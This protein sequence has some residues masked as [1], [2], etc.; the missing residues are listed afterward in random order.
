MTLPAHLL[1]SIQ[2]SSCAE[3]S[4]FHS[5]T[6]FTQLFQAL[7]QL[8][9]SRRAG[10]LQAVQ[11]APEARASLHYVRVTSETPRAAPVQEQLAAWY[12]QRWQLPVSTTQAVL[13]IMEG[14]STAVA[15]AV[16]GLPMPWEAATAQ[17]LQALLRGG[18][19][20]A[21]IAQK[22]TEGG[23]TTGRGVIKQLS[24]GRHS[25]KASEVLLLSLRLLP[26][27]PED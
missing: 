21:G 18:W 17:R 19:T 1:G 11:D 27:Q 6:L 16:P 22:L 13:E 12:A 23:L 25:H 14:S 2:L 7:L 9:E 8:P 3:E 20:Y 5:D 24:R 4:P 26:D 10:L 15:V